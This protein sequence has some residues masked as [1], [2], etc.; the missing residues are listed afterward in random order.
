MPLI[1]GVRAEVSNTGTLSYRDEYEK[2]FKALYSRGIQN[3]RTHL[4]NYV[5]HLL[6]STKVTLNSLAPEVI[7][8]IEFLST[9]TN[10]T[11][12]AWDAICP[13]NFQYPQ[14]VPPVPLKQFP[15]EVH[16]G[17]EYKGGWQISTNAPS[18]YLVNTGT[19]PMD[20][21]LTIDGKLTPN[22]R[23][24]KIPEAP[25]PYTPQFLPTGAQMNFEMKDTCRIGVFKGSACENPYDETQSKL[26]EGVLIAA[27]LD[28]DVYSWMVFSCTGLYQEFS[29]S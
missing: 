11:S 17:T 20:W 3:A 4:T 27:P 29:P 15:P 21:F 23:C 9:L 16:P 19:S 22:T 7:T 25:G 14:F 5:M 6:N 24:I 26:Y 28:F 18:I 8:E 13:E 12:T 1:D 2:W 10:P